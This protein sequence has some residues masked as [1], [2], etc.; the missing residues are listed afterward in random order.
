MEKSKSNQS[1]SSKCIDSSS[2]ALVFCIK[3]QLTVQNFYFSAL[4]TQ[5]LK[6]AMI[7]GQRS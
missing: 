6:E 2:S 4:N 1:Y 3:T 5:I 7:Q